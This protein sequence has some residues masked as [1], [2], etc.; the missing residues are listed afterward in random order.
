MRQSL[1]TGSGPALVPLHPLHPLTHRVPP[2]RI[3]LRLRPVPERDDARYPRPILGHLLVVSP[4]PRAL[5]PRRPRAALVIAVQQA[6]IWIASLQIHPV[7]ALHGT[8]GRPL[9]IPL[10]HLHRA[11]LL[12]FAFSSLPSLSIP[13]HDIPLAEPFWSGTP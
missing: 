7:H 1:C 4:F 3:D 2:S 11:L 6:R 10:L 5:P 9:G 12:P 8:S 13:P